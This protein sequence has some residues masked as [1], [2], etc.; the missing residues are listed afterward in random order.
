MKLYIWLSVLLDLWLQWCYHEGFW[1]SIVVL[2]RT[3]RIWSRLLS[4]GLHAY[5]A[6]SHTTA[7]TVY[8]YY[9]YSQE[10]Q[11]SRLLIC[12]SWPYSPTMCRCYLDCKWLASITCSLERWSI[13]LKPLNMTIGISKLCLLG[14][15]PEP[16]SYLSQDTEN[17][18]IFKGKNSN[19]AIYYWIY[20][21]TSVPRV[22]VRCSRKGHSS[23]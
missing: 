18:S 2:A 8:P 7:L 23:I 21:A 14:F 5:W 20:L 12:F 17:T 22:G 16:I 6:W 3:W 19:I 1:F 13:Q 11:P 15:P 9:L 10:Q 4:V